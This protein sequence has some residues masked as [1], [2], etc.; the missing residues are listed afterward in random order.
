MIGQNSIKEKLNIDVAIST[1]M[2]ENLQLWS[3][4]YANSSAL[5]ER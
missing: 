4:M 1:N 3:L 2:A 5:V